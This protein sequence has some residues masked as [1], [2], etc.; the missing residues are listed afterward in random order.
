VSSELRRIR[1]ALGMTAAEVA[2]V[3]GMSASKMSRMET[4]RRGL[5]PDDV[6]ALLGLYRVP[7]ARREEI[8]DLVR[9][10]DQPGWWQSQ[11][12]G[13]PVLWKDLIDLES[14]ASRVQNFELAVIPGLLQTRDYAAAI[15]RGINKGLTDF[16]LQSLVGT[17]MARQNVLMR[18]D[19]Q[20][21][22]VVDEYA[23][24]RQVGEP[25]LMRRQLRHLAD[26]AERPNVTL[27]LIPASVGS[28]AG[29]R[30]PF[31]IMDFQDEPSVVHIENHAT[32]MFPEEK[33]DV[34][35]YRLA[36]NGILDNALGPA[37]SVELINAILAE[38][39][40]GALE[41]DAE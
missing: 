9:T 5:H 37:E 21:L 12:T 36:L 30:G 13:L 39:H 14:R 40:S 6:S 7:E 26:E 33:D 15:M 10:Q 16:E 3:L 1:E 2:H 25:G 11:G 18:M 17:R 32:S 20:F 28:Y 22:M 34:A 27:R 41:D 8:M 38:H 19:K 4:G 31:M 23:L 24:R 29:L 35:A